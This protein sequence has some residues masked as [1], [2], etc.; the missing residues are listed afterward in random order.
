MPG[1]LRRDTA[2]AA[3]GPALP[4][5]APPRGARRPRLGNTPPLPVFAARPRRGRSAQRL[6]PPSAGTG[7]QPSG[8][9][10]ASLPQEARVAVCPQE[11]LEGGRGP[12]PRLPP[13]R[14]VS[15][16]S[17]AP[18][19]SRASSRASYL[20]A[21]L[22]VSPHL[23]ARPALPGSSAYTDRTAGWAET[24]SAD[25]FGAHCVDRRTCPGPRGYG[26]NLAPVPPAPIPGR[27]GTRTRASAWAALARRRP[28]CAPP[29][30]LGS[31]WGG[32][33]TPGNNAF[34]PAAAVMP[35]P[36]FL[37]SSQEQFLPVIKK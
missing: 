18:R 14:P 3:H 23:F 36:I 16:P 17:R 24:V 34:G 10:Q 31:F 11:T 15:C 26:A 6:P 33:S 21:P 28:C 5:A 19:A 20:P 4:A 7:L 12:A 37:P 27:G 2:P 9:R 29:P 1:N 32:S 22:G 30:N 35:P 13:A 8:E 25:P